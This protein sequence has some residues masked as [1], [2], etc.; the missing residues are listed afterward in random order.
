MIHAGVGVKRRRVVVDFI[1]QDVIGI[2]RVLDDLKLLAGQLLTQGYFGVGD[3][4]RQELG[5]T[6]RRDPDADDD[7]EGIVG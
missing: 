2:V 7:G 3:D 4:Q 6:A 5:G 1:E